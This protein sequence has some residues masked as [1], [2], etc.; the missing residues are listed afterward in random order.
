MR[1]PE[2]WF[3]RLRHLFLGELVVLSSNEE[4]VL[5]YASSPEHLRLS[6]ARMPKFV[7]HGHYSGPSCFVVRRVVRLGNRKNLRQQ[8]AEPFHAS[9][10]D[11]GRRKAAAFTESR[12]CCG[13]VTVLRCAASP[14]VCTDN[15]LLQIPSWVENPEYINLYTC[16]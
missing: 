15:T 16:T 8:E 3:I 6:G 14:H 11:L 7:V 13:V 12:C 5:K 2:A 1:S 9:S 4:F 10:Y